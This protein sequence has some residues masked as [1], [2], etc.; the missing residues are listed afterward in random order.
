MFWI[1]DDTKQGIPATDIRV[2]SVIPRIHD[3]G[4]RQA[5]NPLL[6]IVQIQSKE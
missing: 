6:E 4:K 2:P 1:F 3:P 5:N